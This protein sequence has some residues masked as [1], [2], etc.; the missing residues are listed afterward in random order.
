MILVTGT[1]RSGT[2]M[3]MQ[4]LMAAGFTSFGSAFPANWGQSIKEAN[5]QGFFESRLREGIYYRT[6]PHP[7]T[8][9]FLFPHATRRHLVK[10]FIPGLVRSD[11]AYLDHVV[12]S[13]RPWRDYCS[14][15]ERLC[16]IEDAF[17]E[18]TGG[19]DAVEKARAKRSP[20]P[21]EIEW[22]FENYELIR[23]LA[24]RRYPFQ[25]I[26]H[27]R[28]L[29]EPRGTIEKVLSFLED[30][31]TPLNVEAALAVVE[32]KLSGRSPSNYQSEYLNP[33]DIDVFDAVY[34][35]IHGDGRLSAELINALNETQNRLAK[36]FTLDWREQSS[37][38]RK[39][40]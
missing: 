20:F 19:Q 18:K 4:I 12:A 30:G 6:N 22:W 26:A 5:S 25:L 40:G 7:E 14:S 21:P 34:A 24:T 17:M 2:S 9:Q 13:I 32:P 37:E 3:W 33:Q 11:Y 10:V 29:A 31:Q 8:G 28:L 39:T 16:S 35:S 1:K 27:G 38:T 15:L 36:R 23:D